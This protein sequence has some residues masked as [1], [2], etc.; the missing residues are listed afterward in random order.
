MSS[1][2]WSDRVLHVASMMESWIERN[3]ANYFNKKRLYQMVKK[4]RQQY[5][6]N[7][8]KC[9]APKKPI[10]MGQRSAQRLNDNG[11]LDRIIPQ[12]LAAK[13]ARIGTVTP[14]RYPFE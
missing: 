7:L 11:I 10:L 5:R 1:L 6:G 3:A 4:I 8:E 13:T 2:S 12:G 9:K 14:L